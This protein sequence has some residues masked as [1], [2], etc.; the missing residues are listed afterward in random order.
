MVVDD[1]NLQIFIVYQAVSDFGSQAT[2][3]GAV[4]VF[5]TFL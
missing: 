4:T 2:L 5:V 3:D 1:D